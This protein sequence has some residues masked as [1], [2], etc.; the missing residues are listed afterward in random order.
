V[1]TNLTCPDPTATAER[2]AARLRELDL[3]MRKE[4]PDSILQLRGLI[5]SLLVAPPNQWSEHQQELERAA[6]WLR[7]R[8]GTLQLSALC[9]AAATLEQLSISSYTAASLEVALVHCERA[10][11]E[12]GVS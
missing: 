3:K 6:H 10:L 12:S 4:L 8:A 2:R 9:A 5:H 1:A 11:L 7:G